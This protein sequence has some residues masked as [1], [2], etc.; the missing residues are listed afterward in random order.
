ME[1]VLIVHYGCSDHGKKSARRK[2]TQYVFNKVAYEVDDR[3]TAC[4]AQ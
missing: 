4:A 1:I 2:R 3:H